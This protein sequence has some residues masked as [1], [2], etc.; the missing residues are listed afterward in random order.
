LLNAAG[1]DLGVPLVEDRDDRAASEADLR[2]KIGEGSSGDNRMLIVSGTTER[3][4][5]KDNGDVDVTGQLHVDGVLDLV[6]GEGDRVVLWG[7]ADD[8]EA[9]DLGLEGGGGILY[10][11]AQAG[12]RWYVGTVPDG[13][14]SAR[15]RLNAQRLRIRGDTIVGH[16]GNG[17]LSSRH[18][19]GK[20]FVDDSDDD[21]FLNWDKGTHVVVGNLTGTPSSLWVS[22]DAGVGTSTPRNRLGVR[23]RGTAEE[24]LSFEDATGVT[25]WHINQN[26]GGTNRGLNFAETNVADGR[27]FL[28]DG[29]NVG[30]GT[31]DPQARLDVNGRILRN[32]DDFSST[33]IAVHDEIIEPL[34]GTTMDWNIFVSP[35]EMGASGLTAMRVFECFATVVAGG[36][37]ITARFQMNA[38]WVDGTANYILVPR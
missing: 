3:V 13:G 8:E 6:G 26:L 37:Q 34:W 7:T 38:G 35:R 9:T 4:R 28:S 31:T 1:E 11:R 22:G 15:M 5:F 10:G 33:G 36:W 16:G 20:S 30:V 12:F 21:L 25:H 27:L 29:G 2:V 24:L 32:G 18:V 17:R 23:G 14:T 19:D